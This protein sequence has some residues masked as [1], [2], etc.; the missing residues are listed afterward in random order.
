MTIRKKLTLLYGGLLAVAVIVFGVA[1]LSM[2]RWTMLN[3][4][5]S[6][7]EE[8]ASYII[9][10]SNAYPYRRELGGPVVIGVDLPPLDIFRA[11]NVVVQVWRSTE[12]G[13]EF[14]RGSA[15]L[16]GYRDPLDTGSLGQESAVLHSVGI[17]GTQ[18][19]VLTRP[20]LVQGRLWG[21]V[22]V[23][24]SLQTINETDRKS[25]V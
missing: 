13:M 11:S 18:W 6:A 23:A 16:G 22:Q 4:I 12:A 10:N 24:A 8:T 7:L 20:I 1:V 3:T 19:R 17:G 25:V 5:D 15:N 2:V 14:G 21:N 9:A